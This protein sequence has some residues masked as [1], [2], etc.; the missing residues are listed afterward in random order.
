MPLAQILLACSSLLVTICAPWD[1][2]VVM[3]VVEMIQHELWHL[4]F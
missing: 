2:V 4:L 3:V 1:D